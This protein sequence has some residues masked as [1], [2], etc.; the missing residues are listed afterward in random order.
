MQIIF[1]Q[2]LKLFVEHDGFSSLDDFWE[3]TKNHFTDGF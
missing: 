3:F 1:K 2:D